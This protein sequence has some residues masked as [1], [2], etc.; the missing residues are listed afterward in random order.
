MWSEI[1][2]TIVAEF[3]DIS[4]LADA[5][6]ISLRLLVAAL[7]GAIIGLE[8]EWKSKNAGVRTHMLVA[9]GSAL[10]MI[11]P[12]QAGIG[13]GDMSR[14]IQG[15]VQ[16]VGF[17]GAGAII[18][19]TAQQR[20]RGLTTAAGVWAAAGIGVAAGLGME[21]T[22]VLST[23][24]VLFILTLLPYFTSTKAVDDVDRE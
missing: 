21:M 1:W 15:V 19:G 9:V 10:F 5:V 7:L 14:V 16:G 3:S 22:A 24:I 8:R 20:T 18:I 12:M 2:A 11:G 4:D 23:V 6:R 17:L 13:V